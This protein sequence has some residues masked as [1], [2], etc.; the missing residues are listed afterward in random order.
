MSHWNH[1]VIKKTFE[2]DEEQYGIHEVFYNDDGTIFCYTQDPV[3]AACESMDALREYLQWMLKCLDEDILVD[4]EVEFV[5]DD[6]DDENI[7]TFDD[8]DDLFHSLDE[9]S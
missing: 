7:E 4:G 8:V 5:N 6:S 1:R 2:N 9:E 3:E